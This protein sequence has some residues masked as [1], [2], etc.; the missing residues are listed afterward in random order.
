[1]N[2]IKVIYLVHLNRNPTRWDE[3]RQTVSIVV[4]IASVYVNLNTFYH[5]IFSVYNSEFRSRWRW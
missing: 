3:L 2:L 4:D 1:M 5:F